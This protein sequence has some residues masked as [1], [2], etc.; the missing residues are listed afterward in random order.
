M[1]NT[2]KQPSAPFTFKKNEGV[3]ALPDA[4]IPSEKKAAA[5]RG[6]P[7]RPRDDEGGIRERQVSAYLTTEESEKFNAKLDGRPASTVVRRL[8]LDYINHG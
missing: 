4:A 8:I 1:N 3:H 2:M 7:G 5:G 6:K